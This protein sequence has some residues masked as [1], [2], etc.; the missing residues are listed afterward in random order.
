MKRIFSLL[1]C[2]CLSFST[3]M[4]ASAAAIE[5]PSTFAK[6]ST[7]EINPYFDLIENSI[8][9]YYIIRMSG[10]SLNYVTQNEA[11]SRSKLNTD[12]LIRK[13]N[14]T[15][16]SELS[17][18][19]TMAKVMEE[20]LIYESL[21]MY[22][23]NYTEKYIEGSYNV[24]DWKVIDDLLICHVEAIVKFQ[25]SDSDEPSLMGQL[26]QIALSNPRNPQIV[27]W[28]DDDPA[29]FESVLRGH[30]LNLF[31][32][33]NL[34]EN[35]NLSK[36]NQNA[37]NAINT[38]KASVKMEK[39]SVNQFD[40][41]DESSEL[42]TPNNPILETQTD[43]LSPIITP[44]SIPFDDWMDSRTRAVYYANYIVS[45]SAAPVAAYSNATYYT[46][47]END[48]TNFIS[49]CLFAGRFIMKPGTHLGED[50]W[51]FN[52]VNNRSSSWAGVTPLYRFIK[53]NTSS[54]GPKTTYINEKFISPKVTSTTSP[55][56]ARTGD[57]IQIKY[58][59]SGAY[60]YPD[61]GH[62]TIVHQIDSSND[63]TITWRTSNSSKG[64]NVKLASKYPP[65]P[66]TNDGSGNHIYRLIKTQYIYE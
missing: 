45:S 21:R 46:G 8:E 15:K 25:Y 23:M 2:V 57:I 33:S 48:C 20:K 62:S 56:Q 35:M 3:V 36:I 63:I 4:V 55:T 1:I 52:S 28:Y 9:T 61:F 18:N 58:N 53:G 54:S 49:H 60:A 13:N 50:G 17:L 24:V 19:E 10:E 29:S 59:T 38:Q 14:Q 22:E 6:M 65:A 31:N 51:F 41:Q 43:I 16:L 37:K 26:I 47:F 12:E 40:L 5:K 7:D 34:I 42:Q 30:G 66:N 64:T 27:D 32:P 11:L 44:L 39:E